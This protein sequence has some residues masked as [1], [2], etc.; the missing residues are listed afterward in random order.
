MKGSDVVAL[1]PSQRGGVWVGF[2]GGLARI[3]RGQV[4][5]YPEVQD[6]HVPWSLCEDET[7]ILWIGSD[8]LL[9][10]DPRRRQIVVVDSPARW[11]NFDAIAL[12]CDKELGLLAHYQH[13]AMGSRIWRLVRGE[14]T[15]PRPQLPV[16]MQPGPVDV[17]L[18]RD[19]QGSL[20]SPHPP[21]RL[22]QV[23]GEEV[24]VWPSL[25]ARLAGDVLCAAED[26]E[27]NLWFGTDFAGLLGWQPKRVQTLSATD[28]LAHDNTW[29]L[30][31]DQDGS[32]WIGTDGGLSRFTTGSF[33]NLTEQH[34]LSRNNVRA[35]ALDQ[36]GT[37][38]IGTGSGL[39]SLRDGQLRIHQLPGE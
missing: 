25:T 17:F 26:R 32:V 10:L 5:R 37:L 34:G 24:V 39:N 20:W 21:A 33:T 27:G 11:A 8:C 36:S 3:S 2:K 9:R 29:A 6:S 28:G 30:C 16:D 12:H 15:T 31:E 7:G 1:C 38:W 23:K 19:R 13:G 18:V 22:C 4:D 14:W 35:L